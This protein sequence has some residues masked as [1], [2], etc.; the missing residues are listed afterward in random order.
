MIN[1]LKA[2]SMNKYEK[3]IVASSKVNGSLFIKVPRNVKMGSVE[4][5]EEGEIN[6]EKDFKVA[7]DNYTT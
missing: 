6:T 2:L 3:K 7:Q 5:S 4:E 1:C